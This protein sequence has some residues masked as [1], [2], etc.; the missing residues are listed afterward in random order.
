MFERLNG[1]GGETLSS[2]PK[3]DLKQTYANSN[4]AGDHSGGEQ[5]PEGGPAGSLTL[6]FRRVLEKDLRL[7]C[8]YPR[9]AV[10]I[11]I[12]DEH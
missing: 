1:L 7:L 10:L 11:T 8:A 5:S 6:C 9:D 2:P 3:A 4:P 12:R